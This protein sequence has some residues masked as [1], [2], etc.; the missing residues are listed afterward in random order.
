LLY[1]EVLVELI[2]EN[3]ITVLQ[4]NQPLSVP[5]TETPNPSN[6]NRLLPLFQSSLQAI[7]E[8]FPRQLSP[9]K[10]SNPTL[11]SEGEINQLIEKSAITFVEKLFL[12]FLS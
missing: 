10:K 12:P 6:R 9:S 4:S 3:F 7:Q 8:S 11:I 5:A 1:E 2:Y